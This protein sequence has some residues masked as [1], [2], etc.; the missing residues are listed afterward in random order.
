MI[1][2]SADPMMAGQQGDHEWRIVFDKLP[3]VI[4]QVEAQE[5]LAITFHPDKAVACFLPP[6]EPLVLTKGLTPKPIRRGIRRGAGHE[7][8]SLPDTAPGDYED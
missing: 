2:W 8:M 7:L 4:T 3:P 5:V 6:Q 1:L